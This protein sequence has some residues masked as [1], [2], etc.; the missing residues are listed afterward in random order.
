MRRHP[1]KKQVALSLLLMSASSFAQRKPDQGSL[2]DPGQNTI[3]IRFA[4]GDRTAS[5]RSFALR[6]ERDGKVLIEGRFTSSFKL[7]ADLPAT[8]FDEKIKVNVS[9]G[10]HDWSFSHVPSHALRQ[11]WWWIGTDY[12]PF[13]SEFG[14]DK[15]AKCRIIRYLITSPTQH[16]GFDY[17]ETTPETLEGSKEA[18]TGK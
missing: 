13:Q 7:P 6:V 1:I 17:F 14:G 9:C 18:C 5:C 4:S 16:E 8:S 11:G 15:F 12:P 3:A 2:P 10:K